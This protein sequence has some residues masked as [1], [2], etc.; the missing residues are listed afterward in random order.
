MRHSCV[1]KEYETIT[2]KI[3]EYYEKID[4]GEP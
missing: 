1:Y 4:D 3:K 2:E